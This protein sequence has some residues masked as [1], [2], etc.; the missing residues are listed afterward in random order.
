[1]HL[2]QILQNL[3][4]KKGEIM[5]KKMKV[6]FIGCGGFSSGNHI[7]NTAS[8]PNMEIVAFCDL[9]QSQL[10]ALSEKYNPA[11]VT[12]DMEKIF[13]DPEIEMVVCGTKPDFRLPIMELAVKHNKHLFVEK[14][15]CYRNEE[16]EPMVR[17]MKNSPIKFMVGFNRPY[18]PMMQD[19]KPIYKDMKK[20]SAT[21]IYRIIGEARLWPKHHFDAVIHGK[22]S[23]IIHEVTHIFDLLNWMTDLRPEKVYTV[24]EGNTDNIITLSYPDNVTAVIVAG[25]NSCAGYPKERIEINSNYETLVGE[26]FTELSRYTDQ[27]EVFHKTY[28][29]KMGGQLQNDESREAIVKGSEWRKSITPEEIEVGYYYDKQPKVDKGH[30]NELEYFRR[31]IL[32]DKASETDAISG[33]VANIMAWKAIE[34]WETGAPVEMDFSYLDAL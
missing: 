13:S 25:D 10:D 22:E 8:N 4:F 29:Y 20:G 6:G 9:N 19:L 7:P 33:A 11:Y 24:G 3:E 23:T 32:Q 34:S 16:I 12:S 31:I 2:T 17:L 1:M 5:E 15:L 14:P 28:D 18:S 30:Y 27:G 21:I 26:H